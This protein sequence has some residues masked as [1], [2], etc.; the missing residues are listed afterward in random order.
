MHGSD[1]VFGERVVLL[2]DAPA[3]LPARVLL[4]GPG[5]T[6]AARAYHAVDVVAERRRAEAAEA[7]SVRLTL[8]DDVDIAAAARLCPPSAAASRYAEAV[9][10]LGMWRGKIEN[11][12]PGARLA[13]LLEERPD[14]AAPAPG[15]GVVMGATITLPALP[16]GSAAALGVVGKAAA[17]GA[18]GM[19]AAPGVVGTATGVITGRA[20]AAGAGRQIKVFATNP[21]FAPVPLDGDVWPDTVLATVQARQKLISHL[22]AEQYADIAAL[23]GCYPGIHQFLATE[24]ALALHVTDTEAASLLCV[25]ETLRDRLPETRRALRA[26][27]IDDV[28]AQAIVRAT[29]G[30]N[31]EVARAVE[32]SVL[33]D[34]PQITAVAVRRRAGRAVIAADPDGAADRHRT[35]SSERHVWRQPDVDGMARLGVFGPA[36]DVDTVWRAITACADAPR[37]PDDTRPLGARRFDALTTICTDIMAGGG[38][39]GLRLPDKGRARPAVVVTV[40]FS[41]L[42]GHRAPGELHGHG[43]VCTEQALAMVAGGDLYRMICDPVSGTMLDYGHTRYSPP[44]HLAE[45]VRRR[46]GECP[47]A[48]CHQPAERGHLD[49]IV[50]ARPNPVTGKPTLGTTSADNLAPL[51]PHHHLG[52][53]AG[54]GFA[55]ERAADGTYT[56]TT[57]LGRIYAWRPDPHWHPDTDPV[58]RDPLAKYHESRCGPGNANSHNGLRLLT[59]ENEDWADGF[60][61]DR[62]VVHQRDDPSAAFDRSAAGMGVRRRADDAIPVWHIRQDMPHGI[63]AAEASPSA[64]PC[65]RDGKARGS[66]PCVARSDGSSPRRA[67]RSSPPGSECSSPRRADGS[68]PRRP[69]KSQPPSVSRPLDDLPPF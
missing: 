64:H 10:D 32:R 47:M 6:V 2:G 23:S 40:P 7:L 29:A 58:P 33:P 63:G 21:A 14:A 42:L 22:Q 46:D 66:P 15:T 25:A 67:D 4:P 55:L 35:A 11:C 54:R 61:S 44:P 8:Q 18:V 60:V 39:A 30:C 57:P 69:D 34:A 36:Q 19:A 1:V 26:G 24:L 9:L 38:W 3:A 17:P 51:C 48:S 16:G 12:Q 41:M 65:D 37:A 13:A 52:K 53:D 27:R 45:F 50:P 31:P 68:S 56:W 28:K 5:S 20:T 62:T 43:P 49:H 59:V